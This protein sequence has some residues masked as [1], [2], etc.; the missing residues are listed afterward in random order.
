MRGGIIVVAALTC[1][2]ATGARADEW[3]GFT[4]HANAMIECGYSS[5][6]ECESALGKA[7]TCFIDP[8]VARN[9]KLRAPNFRH[10]EAAAK[11]PSK[12][13]GPSTSAA[14]FE[15]RSART[16]G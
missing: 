10:P 3:C 13:D 1:M 6:N 7:G 16:S 11:R 14:S 12:G 8:D 4:T 2:T 15:A 5:D 9:V